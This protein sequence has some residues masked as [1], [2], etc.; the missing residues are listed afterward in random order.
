MANIHSNMPPK[1]PQIVPHSRPAL[2]RENALQQIRQHLLNAAI[3]LDVA[4]AQATTIPQPDSPHIARAID[5]VNQQT[6]ALLET[7]QE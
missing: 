2:L 5:N 4:H 3:H 1:H 7:L 6:A